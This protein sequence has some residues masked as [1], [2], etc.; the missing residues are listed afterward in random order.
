MRLLDAAVDPEVAPLPVEDVEIE[1]RPATSA[2]LPSIDLL[3][4]LVM[5]LMVLDHARF[6]FAPSPS[7]EYLP[8]SSA[9]LFF[10]RWIT[11]FCAPAFF[12]LAGIS[13]FLAGPMAGR[14]PQQI[15]RFFW[16]RGLWLIL[17]QFTLV[18]FSMDG[19]LF[20]G[21]GGVI[22]CLGL[23]MVMMAWFIRLPRPALAS[24][25]LVVIV[26]HHLLDPL[27]AARFGKFAVLW[28]VLHTPGVY[29]ISPHHEFFTLF[30]LLPWVG[31]MIVGYA[32][33]PVLL[34]LDRRKVL[35]W[36]GVCFTA[37]FLL[38][39]FFNLYGNGSVLSP[40]HTSASGPWAVQG[41]SA[42]TIVSFLNT[43]KYPASLQF[44]L[45]TLGPIFM[46]LA[47]L[48]GADQERRWSKMLLV[49]G[50]VPLL[51]YILHPL[52]LRSMAIWC[53][54]IQRQ[55]AS[56]LQYGGPRFVLPPP[57]YGYSLPFVYGMWAITIVILYY[58]C[59]WFMN[60]KK[61][62]PDWWWLSYL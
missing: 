14:S 27:P 46:S 61:S 35:F 32:F 25:G 8:N 21:Y 48:E 15:R 33:G 5:I 39:R 47:W 42:M 49:F 17:L 34:R 36:S 10:T 2:R 38:L 60:V 24:L 54:W 37:A 53:S 19:L 50:R 41:S 30:T 9:A 31:V 29:L 20:S 1:L 45:M 16:T 57:H 28:S 13:G 56:W 26:G 7:P 3:R 62:H 51:F 44:L 6:Y 52:L 58:P 12:F 22:W 4:G 59:K 23:S 55:D 43:M 18:D 40:F 11:H